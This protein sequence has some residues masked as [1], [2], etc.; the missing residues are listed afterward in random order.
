MYWLNLVVRKHGLLAFTFP[1]GIGVGSGN[2]CGTGSSFAEYVGNGSGLESARERL[3]ELATSLVRGFGSDGEQDGNVR[4]TE[5]GRQ[6]GSGTF[7]VK[8]LRYACGKW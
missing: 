2:D 1:F 3:M 4:E 6:N 5:R 7:A 8:I